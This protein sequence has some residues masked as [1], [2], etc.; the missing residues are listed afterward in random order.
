MCLPYNSFMMRTT[1]L[2]PTD[3]TVFETTRFLEARNRLE[4]HVVEEV[5]L[6]EADIDR[7]EK[8]IRAGKLRGD[9]FPRLSSQ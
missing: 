3:T 5:D 8:A 2:C 4:S 1:S 7:V 9:V 6:S